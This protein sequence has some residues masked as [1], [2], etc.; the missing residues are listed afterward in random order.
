MVVAAPRRAKLPVACRLRS[1]SNWDATVACCKMAIIQYLTSWLFD[2]PGLVSM[3]ASD[4]VLLLILI[5]SAQGA[6][7][8]E[9]TSQSV[10]LRSIHYDFVGDPAG[11]EGYVG[12][13][14]CRSCHQ[15]KVE[16][17]YR[18]AHHLTSRTADK[19]SVVG[20]FSDGAN[21]LRRS[22]PNL[23]F[24]MDATEGAFFRLRYGGRRLIPGR[25]QNGSIS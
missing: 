24:R 2:P 19:E 16:G 23:F 11:N 13:E 12:D 17:Y 6:Q 25:A 15:G 21:V 7:S 22:N 8:P 14:A 20:T 1:T 10:P 9:S 4:V 18:T 3:R 5:Y